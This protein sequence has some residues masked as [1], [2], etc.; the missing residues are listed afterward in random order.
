[1]MNKNDEENNIDM[2]DKN[3]TFISSTEKSDKNDEK[4]NAAEKTLKN[5]YKIHLK[6][7]KQDQKSKEDGIKDEIKDGIDFHVSS[8][9]YAD[10]NCLNY[11]LR[12]ITTLKMMWLSRIW[13]VVFA[14]LV[15]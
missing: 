14:I 13:M 3:S 6:T 12:N 7:N 2:Y 11:N 5:I 9:I 10:I 8:D 1:M 4:I 15:R